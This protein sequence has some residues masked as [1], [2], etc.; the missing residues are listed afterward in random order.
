MEKHSISKLIGS[1]PGYVGYGEGGQ[2]TEKIKHNPYSVILFDEFEKAH[3]DV[4][5]I[6]L[7]VLDDGWLTDAEG[8]RIS[9]RNCL[10]IGTSNIGSHILVDEKKPVG[11]RSQDIRLTNEDRNKEI[12]SEVKKFLRPEFINRLDEIVVFNKL[13]E[14]NL[15]Q[16][17]SI[18]LAELRERTKEMSVDLDISKEVQDIILSSIDSYQYGARPLKRKLQLLVENE[19]ANLLIKKSASKDKGKIKVAVKSG[20]IDVSYH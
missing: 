16:I 18:Q 14:E 2:L 4:Y 10:I 9:F 15:K 8:Q 5:N 12:I 1:P 13:S 11:I 3:T 17:L 19:I 7:S 6:L 20:K